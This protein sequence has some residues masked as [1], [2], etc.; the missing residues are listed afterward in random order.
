[1]QSIPPRSHAVHAYIER[2]QSQSYS[3]T[4]IYYFSSGG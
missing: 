2:L 1:M 4:D 3:K